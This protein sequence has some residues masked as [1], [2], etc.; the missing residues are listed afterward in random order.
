[1]AGPLVAG[2]PLLTRQAAKGAVSNQKENPI[3]SNKQQP[4]RKP[5]HGVFHIRGEGP[6]GSKSAYWTK[7]G[8]AWM[9]DD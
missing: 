5:T 4:G 1:M 8:A 7:I 2:V 6:H 9:H 3:M